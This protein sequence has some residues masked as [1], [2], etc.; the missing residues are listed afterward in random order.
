MIPFFALEFTFWLAAK[1]VN[2][3]KRAWRIDYIASALSFS[4]VRIIL[5]DATEVKRL[6]ITQREDHSS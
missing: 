2:A 4:V 1:T 3:T 6:S 5:L